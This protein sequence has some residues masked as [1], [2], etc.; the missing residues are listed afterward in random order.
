M[1][2]VPHRKHF[3]FYIYVILIPH[4]STCM[5]LQSPLRGQLYSLLDLCLCGRLTLKRGFNIKSSLKR[6]TDPLYD[7]GLFHTL[8]VL[9]VV[10]VRHKNASRYL[11]KISDSSVPFEKKTA[12]TFQFRETSPSDHYILISWSS[13]VFVSK[14]QV[15][16]RTDAK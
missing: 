16:R 12:L 2:F 15:V 1:M 11:C 9:V 14:V 8:H 6:H 4:R 5:D 3:N 10:Q 7:K 13:F